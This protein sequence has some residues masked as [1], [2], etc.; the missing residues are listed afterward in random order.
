MD[1]DKYCMKCDWIPKSEK[2]IYCE[3]CGAT[4]RLFSNSIFCIECG[5]RMPP[6]HLNSKCGKCGKTPGLK[7]E[8]NVNNSF[9]M[10]IKVVRHKHRYLEFGYHSIGS[11]FCYCG[12]R[13]SDC[14]KIGEHIRHISAL[15]FHLEIPI[16]FHY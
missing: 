16:D 3:L 14:E 15:K 6:E 13:F 9:E 12:E 7:I 5:Y 11:G 1:T 10:E 2:A 4:L 8:F